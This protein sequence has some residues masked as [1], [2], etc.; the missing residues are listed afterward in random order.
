MNSNI[1]L[2]GTLHYNELQNL[3]NE[4]SWANNREISDLK[5]MVEN[6]NIV[7]TVFDSKNQKL[8]GFARV[9]TDYIFRASIWDVVVDH[10]YHGQG[11]GQL[12]MNNIL[13]HSELIKVSKFWLFTQ[14]KCPFY[15]KFGFKS[16]SGS[17]VLDR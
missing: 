3:L 4:T 2:T 15:E 17:M 10:H 14:D 9:L 16:V 5:I 6:S 12:I 8:I 13:N 11:I 1:S 7:I